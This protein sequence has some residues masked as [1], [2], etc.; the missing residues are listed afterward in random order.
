MI[1][2]KNKI[3]AEANDPDTV[4]LSGQIFNNRLVVGAGNKSVKCKYSALAGNKLIVSTKTGSIKFISL[5]KGV[6]VVIGTDS[7]GEIVLYDRSE[8]S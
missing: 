6:D 4:L 1:R 5:A 7:E 2:T 3:L 8:I